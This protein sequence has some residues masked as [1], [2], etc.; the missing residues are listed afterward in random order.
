MLNIS[1]GDQ[2]QDA[3]SYTNIVKQIIKETNMVFIHNFYETQSIKEHKFSP[4]TIAA[5]MTL[6]R[7][8]EKPPSALSIYSTKVYFGAL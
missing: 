1:C 3:L 7:W 4:V 8:F 2:K 5:L 6:N